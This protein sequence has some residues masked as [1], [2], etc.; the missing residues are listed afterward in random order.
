MLA[1]GAV[2]LGVAAATVYDI[3]ARRSDGPDGPDGPAGGDREWSLRA[4]AAAFVARVAHAWAAL[5][6]RLA[7]WAASWTAGVRRLAL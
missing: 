6:Q 5:V 7:T 4:A 1:I 3:L 2:F